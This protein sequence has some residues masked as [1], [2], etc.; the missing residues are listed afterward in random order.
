MKKQTKHNNGNGNITQ[1]IRIEFTHPTASEVAIAGTFNDWRPDATRMVRLG[2]GRWSKELALSPGTYEY[3]L[4][5]DGAWMV[6]PRA[7]ET[8]PNPFGGMNSVLKVRQ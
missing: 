8:A 2:D 6:D 7:S 3:R 1:R 4:V 5:V